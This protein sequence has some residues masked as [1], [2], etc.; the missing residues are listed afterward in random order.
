MNKQQ[1][2]TQLAFA[3]A[4]LNKLKSLI[5]QATLPDNTLDNRVRANDLA[6]RGCQVIVQYINNIMIEGTMTREYMELEQ[7]SEVKS[8]E[9]TRKESASDNG[10]YPED[11]K[12]WFPR[13]AW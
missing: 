8:E 7:G 1:I 6:Q 2:L 13:N 5:E 3:Q 9:D 10:A 11:T 4:H 12:F